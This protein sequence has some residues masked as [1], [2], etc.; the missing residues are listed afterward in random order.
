MVLNTIQFHYSNN[1]VKVNNQ[2]FIIYNII[3]TG[4]WLVNQEND[5]GQYLHKKCQITAIFT[6]IDIITDGYYVA[7][8]ASNVRY[9]TFIGHLNYQKRN[10][11]RNL[12]IYDKIYKNANFAPY[13]C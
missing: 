8:S 7:L 9:L 2:I 4:F 5:L 13:K 6:F 12:T 10:N 11:L 3:T 1:W